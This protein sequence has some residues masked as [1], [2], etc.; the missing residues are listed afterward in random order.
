[1]EYKVRT[2]LESKVMDEAKLVAGRQGISNIVSDAIVMEAHDI[3]KWLKPNQLVLTSL[4]SLQESSEKEWISFIRIMNEMDASG[5]V[6]KLGRFVENLPDGIIEGGDKY[7]LP[8]IVIGEYVEYRD[9]ILEVMQSVLNKKAKMLDI[10]QNVHNE[11]KKLSLKDA[12]VISI[13]K[14]LKGL[15]HKD[16]SLVSLDRKVIGT[17]IENE[18][19]VK[20]I[21]S[22]KLK[23][24]SYLTYEYTRELIEYQDELSSQLLVKIN[25]KSRKPV[26]LVVYEIDDFVLMSDYM[27]IENACNSIQFEYAKKLALSKV[28]QSHMNDSVDQILNGKY[29]SNE[30]L[31][32]LLHTLKLSNN[33]SYRIITWLHRPDLTGIKMSFTEREELFLNNHEIIKK[34]KNIWPSFAYRIF[35][36]RLTF[37]IEDNFKQDYEFKRY[38]KSSLEKFCENSNESL[39]LKVGI[40]QNSEVNEIKQYA[41]QPLKVIKIANIQKKESFVELYDDLGIYRLFLDLQETSDLTAY[42]REKT[43]LMDSE[44]RETV[45]IFLDKNQNYKQTSEILFI[46]PKTV[47]YRIDKIKELY[48]FDFDDPTEMFQLMVELRIKEFSEV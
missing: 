21:D 14:T 3:E 34:I 33:K 42:I 13:L 32:D 39:V 36:N 7:N 23:R 22:R 44:D 11:F 17:T 41:Q 48:D 5:L 4:Y 29:Q 10:Y 15:I 27:A 6:V 25:L 26:Y 18:G 43:Q 40:S 38:I 9:I 8:V 46:H 2:F 45:R 16:I 31:F 30:E 37:I 47:K 1:M 20:V 35:S 28:K 24:E 19:T 12:S